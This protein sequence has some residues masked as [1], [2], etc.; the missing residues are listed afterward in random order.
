MIEERGM[1]NR[2]ASDH[3]RYEDYQ[4]A[5]SVLFIV[6]LFFS[7]LFPLNLALAAEKA[8]VKEIRYW[9]SEGHTRVTVDLSRPVEF[10]KR[11]LSS[12]DRL[13]FDLK[14][15]R[16]VKE[17]QNKLPVGDGILKSVRAGQYDP[18]TVRIVLDLETMEDFNS[19]ILDDPTKLVI[20]VNAKRPEKNRSVILAKKI[21]VIDPGH[22]G[23]DSGA[24]GPN[25]LKEKDVVLDIALKVRALLSGEPNIKLILTRDKDVFI[26]LPDRTDIAL[27]NDADLFVSIHANASPR[28]GAR[29]IETYLQNWTNEEEAIRVAAREN[30]VSVKRMKQKMAQYRTDD[31]G[32]ILSDLNRDVKRDES[33][34]LANY[35]QDSLYSSVAKV[36]KKTVNLGVKQAMFFVL[37]GA[38]MPSILAEVS[39]ISNPDEEKLLSSDIYR[40]ILAGS[41][42]A[43]IRTYF[44]SSAPFQRTASKHRNSAEKHADSRTHLL[45]HR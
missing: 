22:G 12:P 42:A 3:V 4:S 6:L 18:D 28:S 41:I 33:I 9:S 27:R 8:E 1:G 38:N 19:F 45:A 15:S 40:N 14:N 16:I 10:T 23:H 43:G 39:F 24:V 25:G 5:R 35:V 11:R 36:H 21:L 30:Y 2:N 17:I 37:M 26:P 32:K 13:Y 29:G 34:A 7:F 31:V 44:S 20:I